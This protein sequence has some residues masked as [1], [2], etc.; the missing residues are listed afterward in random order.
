MATHSSSQPTSP[1]VAARR[2]DDLH[3]EELDAE[4]VVF[5]AQNGA[6][7]R[8]DTITF[9]V[10]NTC[11]GKRTPTEFANEVAERYSVAKAEAVAVVESALEQLRDKGLLDGSPATS[12]VLANPVDRKLSRR[13]VLTGGV[14][15]AMLVAPVISTFFAAGAY[16][17]G[18]S[19]SAAWGVGDCKNLGYS[20][21]VVGDCCAGAGAC[22]GSKCVP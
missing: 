1:T 13:E 14:G 20:C 10:W 5:D 22:T 12:G 18:P 16:A 19:F 8:L 7:H 17:S 9:F 4:A 21:T 6:V 3:V 11:D 2:R 15:K